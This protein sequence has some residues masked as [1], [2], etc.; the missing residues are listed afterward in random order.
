MTDEE[1]KRLLLQKSRKTIT[2]YFTGINMK[3]IT[4]KFQFSIS[5]GVSGKNAVV[6]IAH[7]NIDVEGVVTTYADSVYTS[8]KHNHNT[9]NLA[10]EG[11]NVD[12][13]LDDATVIAT[14][15]GTEGNITMQ[16]VNS[17]KSIAH[18]LEYLKHN[19]RMVKNIA[20]VVASTTLSEKSAAFKSMS[21]ASLNPFHQESAREIDLQQYFSENQFQS[22]K[23]NI[24][25]AKGDFEW[26]DLLFWSIVVAQGTTLEITVD[27]YEE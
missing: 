11:Y 26:N 2:N 15:S 14:I 17:N 9:E 13:V 6:A 18:T 12:A 27:F 8:T 7:A 22:G 23:I 3:N 1:K 25:Y 10:K 21:L 5:N 24:P 16:A 19:P 4:D 20:I